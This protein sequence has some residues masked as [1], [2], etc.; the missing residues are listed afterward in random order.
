MAYSEMRSILAR[1]L[2]HFEMELC[3]ESR[4]WIDQ[5]VH[6]LWQKPVLKVKLS[7]RFRAKEEG[8]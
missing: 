2:W 5:K 7:R 3:D 6:I 4:N 1:M 8:L